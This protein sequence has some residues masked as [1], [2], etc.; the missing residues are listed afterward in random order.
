MLRRAGDPVAGTPDEVLRITVVLS[1]TK[2]RSTTSN[3]RG[4]S[5][6]SIF[7]GATVDLRQAHL[8]PTG[9]SLSVFAL[10]AGTE[11]IVPRGW[12]LKARGLPIFG[13]FDNKADAQ[14]EPGTPTLKI[15]ATAIFGGIEIK[16]EK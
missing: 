12:H 10:F 14:A 8:N 4:G 5:I 1:S 7:G 15:E 9:A 6:T 11:I 3:L 2:V 13:G 16:H